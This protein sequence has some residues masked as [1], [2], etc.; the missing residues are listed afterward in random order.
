[1]TQMNRFVVL[2]LL[3]LLASACTLQANNPQAEPLFRQIEAT[4]TETI[5]PST[6]LPTLTPSR[7][8]LPPPTFEPPTL[9]PIPSNTP[10][11]TLTPTFVLGFSI[12]G[13]NGLETATPTGTPGCEPRKD[14][15][16]TY[17]VQA[18]DALA[19][20]AQK[21]GTYVSDLAA[22]NCISDPNVLSIGQVLRV[23]GDVQPVEQ[24]YDCAFTLLTP[25]NGTMAISGDGTL[26]FNWRGPRAA[27]NLIRIHKPNGGTYEVVVELRQN[28]TID[29][30]VIPDAGTYTWYVFPLDGNFVQIPCLEGGPWTFQKAQMPTPTPTSE[31][32]GGGGLGQ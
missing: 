5:P 32:G 10:S 1:M 31:L 28:E 25:Q 16:L 4:A 23:P 17:T 22:A 6:P 8:L 12:E 21:Y 26:T 9:T 18:N 15:K 11:P 14:W 7:T 13:L 2:V 3:A 27:R 30:S 24:I 29:L 20:I 19:R